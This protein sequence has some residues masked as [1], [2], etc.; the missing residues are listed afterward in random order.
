MDNATELDD[1]IRKSREVGP[2]E[3]A[4]C[5]DPACKA[6][7]DYLAGKKPEESRPVRGV[8][9]N[10]RSEKNRVNKLSHGE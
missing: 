9:V 3:I 2:A 7:A 6:V 8:R 4:N 5:I 10:A 1:F